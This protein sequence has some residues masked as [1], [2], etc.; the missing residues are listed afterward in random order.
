MR[1]KKSKKVNLS[2]NL[3]WKRKKNHGSWLTSQ[4]YFPGT[5]PRQWL[6]SGLSAADVTAQSCSV[7]IV[8]RTPSWT[9]PMTNWIHWWWYCQSH[10]VVWP[11]HTR[12]RF[13]C[14]VFNSAEVPLAGL[15]LIHN[16]PRWRNL[17]CQTQKKR[18]FTSA[19]GM[20]SYHTFLLQRTALLDCTSPSAG[21][22]ISRYGGQRRSLL[23]EREHQASLM[24]SD[25]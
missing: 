13:V 17:K 20:S 12:A 7:S 11:E 16:G 23:F 9:K 3:R 22:R 15:A 21:A 4:R 18:N 25:M 6:C 24:L 1:K 8:S 19:T 5:W 14:G 10:D 2:A